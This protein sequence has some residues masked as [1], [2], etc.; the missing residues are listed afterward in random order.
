MDIKQLEYFSAVC[1]RGSI[2]KAAECLYTTQPNVSKVINSL[3]SE[4]GRALFN[5]SH[6]GMVLTP[7]GRTIRQ[8]A[9]GVLRHV[10]LIQDV[11]LQGAPS[12]FSIACYRSDVIS[13]LLTK[14]YN[15]YK[16]EVLTEYYQG[17]LEEITDNVQKGICE[18]G[19]VYVAKKQLQIF[20]HVLKHKNLLFQELCDMPICIYIGPNHPM[21]NLKS[22]DFKDLKMLHAIRG[23]KDFFALEHHLKHIN[24][25]VEEFTGVSDAFYTNSE[26]MIL[27]LLL[28]TELCLVGIDSKYKKYKDYNI[29]ALHVNGSDGMITTGYI[30]PE[31]QELSTYAK[32]F[33]EQYSSLV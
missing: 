32:N 18:I 21:Y 7:Y 16:E 11:A 24:V 14:F 25:G 10:K 17:S 19:I 5:R 2:N 6:K 15:D 3:E 27:K 23:V 12:K 9:E 31:G 4:L 20:S 13:A 22:I 30:Y 28:N 8:Y 26:A 33:I 1:E 29:K